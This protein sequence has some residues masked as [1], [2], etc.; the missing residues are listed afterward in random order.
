MST[1]T[2]GERLVKIVCLQAIHI[3][4]IALAQWASGLLGSENKL[5]EPGALGE[6]MSVMCVVKSS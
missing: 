2:G 1:P 3:M 5:F 4:R 6:D